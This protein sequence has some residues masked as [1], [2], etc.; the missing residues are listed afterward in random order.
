MEIT[1]PGPP[2]NPACGFPRIGLPPK[3]FS[4]VDVILLL[5]SVQAEGVPEGPCLLLN[6]L[7]VL[8]SVG[9]RKLISSLFF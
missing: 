1:L 6:I 2:Q 4:A 5:E 3:A 7:G 9:N 8:G